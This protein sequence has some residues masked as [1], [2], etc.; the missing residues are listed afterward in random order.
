MVG[1]F[2]GHGGKDTSEWISTNIFDALNFTMEEAKD[3]GLIT[4]DA[5]R[6]AHHTLESR[7]VD[8]ARK[9][10]RLRPNSMSGVGSCSLTGLLQ[11]DSNGTLHLDIANLGDSMAAIVSSKRNTVVSDYT[12]SIVTNKL[13]ANERSEQDRLKREHPNEGDIVFCKHPNAC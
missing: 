8:V 1:V 4:H 13:N 7:W 10:N 12:A 6:R 11:K 2:D 5:I 9:G 3:N